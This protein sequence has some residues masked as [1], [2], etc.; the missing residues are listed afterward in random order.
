MPFFIWHPEEHTS[1]THHFPI[2]CSLACVISGETSSD[3]DAFPCCGRE[4]GRLWCLLWQES[5]FMCKLPVALYLLGP[6]R[7]T[8]IKGSVG[9]SWVCVGFSHGR[10]D[11]VR[12][13]VKD[14]QTDSDVLSLFT[15]RVIHKNKIWHTGAAFQQSVRFQVLSVVTISFQCQEFCTSVFRLKCF[16]LNTSYT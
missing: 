11:R 13:V 3:L 4:K 9:Q 15:C 5:W 6:W 7:H 2:R 8:Q 12:V 10:D 14:Y 1:A 16:A